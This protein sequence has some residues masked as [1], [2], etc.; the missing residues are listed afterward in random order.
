MR[1]GLCEFCKKELPLSIRKKRFCN[2]LCQRKHYNRRPEIREKNRIRMKEYRKNNPIWREKHLILQSRY[3][4]KRRLYREKYFKRP[5]VKK[6]M[7]ERKSWQLKNVPE[8]AVADRLRISLNHALTKYSDKGKIMGSKKY[9]IN[10]KEILEHLKPFPKNLKD[11]EVD[12]IIPLRTFNL[13]NPTEVKTA[14]SPQNL[15]WLTKLENRRKGGGI[16]QS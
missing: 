7:K 14:F 12:H 9:G 1:W 6:K 2:D 13:T 15:Q 4:E 3:T 8:F 5:D 11:F 10:W 16:I